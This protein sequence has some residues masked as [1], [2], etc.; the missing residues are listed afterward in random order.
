MEHHNIL[1]GCCWK[2]LDK[3]NTDIPLSDISATRGLWETG[4][5]RLIRGFGLSGAYLEHPNML[6]G[7]HLKRPDQDNT[8]LPLSDIFATRGLGNG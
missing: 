4:K 1:L 5:S 7:S 6:M 3:A 8:D 2:R